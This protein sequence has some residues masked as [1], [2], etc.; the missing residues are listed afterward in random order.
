MQ[1]CFVFSN[2]FF[3]FF[4]DGV[5]GGE[6]PSSL[7]FL[8]WNSDLLA[9]AKGWDE[10]LVPPTRQDLFL[11]VC[12][13]YLEPELE[14]PGGRECQELNLRPLEKQLVLLVYFI[15]NTSFSLNIIYSEYGIHFLYPFQFLP[16]SLPSGSTPF[17]SH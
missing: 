13:R 14:P 4:K 8:A 1:N 16:T 11:F 15:E 10:K 17:L 5:G 12:V 3:F 7:P 9:S 2:F 6:G